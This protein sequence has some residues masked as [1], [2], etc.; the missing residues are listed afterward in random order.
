MS[1]I[2]IAF[3]IDTIGSP[4]A[5]TEKQ[6]LLLL[7]YLD[8]SRFDP[9]LCCLQSSKWLETEFD[10][11]PL[12]IVNIKSFLKPISYLQILKLSL[13]FKRNGIDIVQTYFR[14]A[15]IA[16][17]IAAKIAWIKVIVSTRVCQGYWYTNFE[18]FILKMLN[19]LVTHFTANCLDTARFTNKVEKIP[20]KKIRVIHNG[21]D[22]ELFKRAH[23]EDRKKYRDKLNIPDN[24]PVVGI[25]ANLRPVKGLDV[26]LKAARL[27]ATQI[28]EVRF[29]IVG[30]GVEKGHLL[31]MVQNSNLGSYVSFLGKVIDV[32]SLLQA[33]DIGVLSSYSE[34]FSNAILEYM[35]AGLPVVCTDTGGNREAI[36]HEKN[37]FIVPIGEYE[38]MANMIVR[39]IKDI[40]LAKDMGRKNKVK[41]ET[42]FSRHTFLS[43]FES[44]Y[45]E[46]KVI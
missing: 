38:T 32:A 41:A 10:L 18:L 27:V 30:D 14:D 34:S 36:T 40:H 43:L 42:M 23:E 11:C 17:I 35:I 1:K 5:G 13:F 37:G 7:R 20:I 16:G 25:V 2:K 22:I 44:F 21:L 39:I 3:I 9:Y 31:N 29:L 6:L 4:T 46:I 8:R 24:S 28:P 19:P 12:Y 33:V 45:Q 15:N 26:F